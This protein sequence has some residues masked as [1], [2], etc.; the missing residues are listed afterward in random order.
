MNGKPH[1]HNITV[2]DRKNS[3]LIIYGDQQNE[4]GKP[5]F[6]N[7]EQVLKNAIKDIVRK[8]DVNSIKAQ[9][10]EEDKSVS[11]RIANE[12]SRKIATLTPTVDCPGG[13]SDFVYKLDGTGRPITELAGPV[14]HKYCQKCGGTGKIPQKWPSEAL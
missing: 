14:T 10:L 7:P 4:V 6:R 5:A 3:W 13:E 11:Q 8:H 9:K 2:R 1:I 12:A